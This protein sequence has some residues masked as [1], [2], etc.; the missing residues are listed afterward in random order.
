MDSINFINYFIKLNNNLKGREIPCEFIG[1]CKS[2]NPI[3]DKSEIVSNHDELMSN[4]F[5]Q[6]DALVM[7]F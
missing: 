4:F 7:Y 2:Q 6:P 3:K 1:F 5:S